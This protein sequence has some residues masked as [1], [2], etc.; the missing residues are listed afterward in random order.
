M[1]RLP[2]LKM[3]IAKIEGDFWD[4]SPPA[5]YLLADNRLGKERAD[6]KKDLS[7]VSGIARIGRFVPN[8]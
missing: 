1:S 3:A 8:A 5:S 6:G 4:K 7:L 2:S